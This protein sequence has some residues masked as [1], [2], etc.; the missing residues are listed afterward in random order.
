MGAS[1]TPAD[2][3]HFLRGQNKSSLKVSHKHMP[4]SQPRLYEVS[5]CGPWVITLQSGFSA[6]VRGRLVTGQHVPAE[7]SAGCRTKA[8]TAL[9][10]IQ[11]TLC[12]P[13]PFLPFQYCPSCLQWS[14]SHFI[15]HLS[16][17]F[18]YQDDKKGNGWDEGGDTFKYCTTDDQEDY[19][20]PVSQ[21]CPWT[22]WRFLLC[23]T[24]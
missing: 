12:P 1:P 2:S 15:W 7:S 17:Q 14:S 8:Q 6:D 23:L 19:P 4:N 11:S 21:D 24:I 18:I 3:A 13:G 10:G 5:N 20:H 9:L 22:T 16:N